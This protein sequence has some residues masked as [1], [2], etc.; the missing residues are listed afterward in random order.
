MQMNTTDNKHVAP[1]GPQEY[2]RAVF[3][4]ESFLEIPFNG[5]C[6]H[7]PVAGGVLLR[8]A[9]EVSRRGI[10]TDFVSETG[11]DCVG[12]IILSQLESCGVGSR[13]VDVFTEGSSATHLLFDLPQ[14]TVAYGTYPAE[15]MSVIWPRIDVDSVVVYGGTYVLEPRVSGQVAEILRYARDRRA[16][17]VYVPDFSPWLAHRITRYMPVILDNLENSDLIVTCNSDLKLLFGCENAEQ[18][19]KERVGF[20]ADRMLNIADERIEMFGLQGMSA[21]VA[22]NFS[23]MPEVLSAIAE[24]LA[25]SSINHETIAMTTTDALNAFVSEIAARM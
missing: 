1:V 13:S 19:F 2:R 22:G 25:L 7:E 12:D 9:C 3:I 10:Q 17:V 14:N 23:R 11:R 4:G 5:Q 6:V 20:H 15:D 16:M 21:S 24:T 8:A 18:A